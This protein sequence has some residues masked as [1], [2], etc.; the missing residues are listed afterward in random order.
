MLPP[1]EH[2]FPVDSMLRYDTMYVETGRYLRQ[3]IRDVQ[4]AGGKI[5]VRK[6]ATPADIAALPKRWSS[7]APALA[8][9]TCSA[10]RTCTRRAASSP[11]SSRSPR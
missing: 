5:E 10:T 6:F 7:T 1:A 3:M 8:A 9:A 11:S 4:I 2:P